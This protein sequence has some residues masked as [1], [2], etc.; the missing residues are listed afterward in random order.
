MSAGHRCVL[1][2]GAELQGDG[3]IVFPLW[4]PV[5]A[6]VCAEFG[7]GR[8]EAMRRRDG[9]WFEASVDVRADGEPLRA[10][11]VLQAPALPGCCG[12]VFVRSADGAQR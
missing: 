6:R 5:Q 2:F 10:P 9:G 12:A 3:R 11:W 4:A 7:Q 8:L 1:P